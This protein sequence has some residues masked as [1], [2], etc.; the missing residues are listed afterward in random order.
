M[1]YWFLLMFSWEKPMENSWQED[2]ASKKQRKKKK[3][4]KVIWQTFRL[5]HSKQTGVIFYGRLAAAR[6]LLLMPGATLNKRQ[7]PVASLDVPRRFTKLLPKPI[8]SQEKPL[9]T[10]LCSFHSKKCSPTLR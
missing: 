8:R 7:R 9:V 5:S 4:W 10:V 2:A 6:G 1:E 3:T